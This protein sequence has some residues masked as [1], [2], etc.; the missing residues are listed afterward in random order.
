[1]EDG[2]TGVGAEGEHH[3]IHGQTA[4]NLPH[5]HPIESV[6]F[7]NSITINPATYSTMALERET[8]SL[9]SNS[10]MQ[11]DGD[12]DPMRSRRSKANSEL[13]KSPN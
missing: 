7:R 11:M 4:P 13:R 3:S 12:V 5:L 10:L 1:M 2:S 6:G 9:M 8:L